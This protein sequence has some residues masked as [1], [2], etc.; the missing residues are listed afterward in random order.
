[1]GSGVNWDAVSHQDMYD[2]INGGAGPS[3]LSSSGGAWSN[4]SNALRTADFWVSAISERA[5]AN[6]KGTGSEALQQASSPFSDWADVADSYAKSGNTQ[7]VAQADFF[8]TARD[9]IPPPNTAPNPTT[10]PMEYMQ[11][12]LAKQLFGI[13]T[14]L[15]KREAADRVAQQQAADAMKTYDS[16]TYSEVRQQYFSAPPTIA[17]S[18]MAPA[19]PTLSPGVQPPRPGVVEPQG[20]V[21]PYV[22]PM[23]GGDPRAASHAPYRPSPG[24]A[25]A[26]QPDSQPANNP[27]HPV[28][29]AAYNPAAY[30][31]G[32]A[33]GN[34]PAAY[35]AGPVAG[36]PGVDAHNPAAT[37]YGHGSDGSS[38]NTSVRPAG[39]T[40]GTSAGGS[41]APG[42]EPFFGGSGGNNRSSA[43]RQYGGVGAAAAA[44]AAPMM[45]GGGGGG[46]DSAVDAPGSSGST[47]F[48]NAGGIGSSSLPG[49]GGSP[50]SGTGSGGSGPGGAS[51][52]NGAGGPGESAG[53]R[54]GV[55]PGGGGA[56]SAGVAAERM[57]AGGRGGGG[58]G[59]M[60]MGGGGR[61]K[62]GEDDEHYTPEFLKM[63][64]PFD[65]GRVIA[66]P[67]IGAEDQG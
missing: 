9:Q 15:E 51:G 24:Q 36:N 42:D 20:V 30:N 23:G 58:M 48:R 13:T 25:G 2:K 29:P 21:P 6:W 18:S 59:G 46:G 35:N 47:G 45:L 8:T 17:V 50:A 33:P 31:P 34:H 19:S 26:G 28:A 32:S 49:R 64:N 40:P 55:G 44:G 65:D 53:A 62:G 52:S 41:A 63:E 7:S 1:M 5:A 12:S 61:G 56:S 39:Y 4:L 66:P 10:T 3:S 54:S 16:S 22:P 37:G 27:N 43:D 11:Q 60:P 67:V 38:T 57:A 14:D